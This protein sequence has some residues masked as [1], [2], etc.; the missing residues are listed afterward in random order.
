M[1]THLTFRKPAGAP[2]VFINGDLPD[3]LRIA[4]DRDLSYLVKN[5]DFAVDAANEKILLKWRNACNEAVRTG[6]K[7]PEKPK[8]WDGYIRFLRKAKSGSWYFPIGLLPRVMKTIRWYDVE[9][10][11]DIKYNTPNLEGGFKWQGPEMRDYQMDVITKAISAG[12]G[13][14]SLPT[15]S[16]KTLIALRLVFAFQMPTIVLVHRRELFSQWCDEIQKNLN[17]VPVNYSDAVCG[18]TPV[19]DDNKEHPC[20][21]VAMIQTL[22]GA[23]KNKNAVAQTILEARYDVMVADEIH[24]FAADTFYAVG[25]KID[26]EHRFGTSATTEREDGED[27]KFEAVVGPIVAK[28]SAEGLIDRGYLARPVFEF[29]DVPAA[30]TG[31][32]F[33]QIYKTG[34]V[35]NEG[36]N[37]AIAARVKQLVEEGRQVYIHV[38]R[39]NHGKILSKLMNIPFVYSKSKDR[40]ETIDTFKKGYTRALCSTLLSEGFDLVSCGAIVMAS[41]MKS[42]ISV[43]QRV[44]RALRPDP[45]FETAVVVDFQ[46]KGRHLGEH[47]LSRYNTYVET[48][49]E[50]VVRRRVK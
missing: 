49:G 31:K 38:E 17:L 22:Y 45:N 16:G 43:I 37:N 30:G 26:A 3:N 10:T 46:D 44:G 36:R 34:I 23:E 14:I 33:A 18:F 5:A 20:V 39:V 2:Y 50:D 32:T 48:Y 8:L 21:I 27:M 40:D 7:A 47:T 28:M 41:G 9:V 12:G 25:M 13:I 29:I 15:G 42:K 6:K 1:P 35:L 24:H 19:I 4:L 11:T